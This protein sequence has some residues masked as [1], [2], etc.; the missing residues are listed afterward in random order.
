MSLEKIRR[1]GMVF[2]GCL[3]GLIMAGFGISHAIGAN[4][5]RQ[6][7]VTTTAEPLKAFM[8]RKLEHSKAILEGLAIEDFDLIRKNSQGPKLMGLESNWNLLQTEEYLDQSREFRRTVDAIHEAAEKE[9]LESAAL[10]YVTLTVQCVE[11]HK[12]LRSQR[13]QR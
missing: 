10:R 2:S 8:R 11:C 6:D 5:S 9:N 1:R 12:Y 7:E 13:P 4:D 3:L